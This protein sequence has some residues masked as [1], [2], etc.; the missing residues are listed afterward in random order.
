MMYHKIRTV[1][2]YS[3]NILFGTI[4]LNCK[5][6]EEIDYMTYNYCATRYSAGKFLRGKLIFWKMLLHCIAKQAYHTF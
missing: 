3:D 4:N 6:Y 5:E 2:T 1:K